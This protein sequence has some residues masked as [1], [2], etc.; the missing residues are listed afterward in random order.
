MLKAPAELAGGQTDQIPG[1]MFEV[2][3]VY[4]AFLAALVKETP[5]KKS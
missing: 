1:L 3:T 5:K 2:N 4:D